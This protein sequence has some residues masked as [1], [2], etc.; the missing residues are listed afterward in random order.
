V[1]TNFP[2][3]PPFLFFSFFLF[4]PLSSLSLFFYP[5][6]FLQKASNGGFVLPLKKPF[7]PPCGSGPPASAG[8]PAPFSGHELWT[9]P[10]SKPPLCFPKQWV[11]PPLC[12]PVFWGESGLFRTLPCP[13][14]NP[15]VT[16][17]NPTWVGTPFDVGGELGC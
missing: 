4:P 11:T 17:I 5:A 15:G 9:Q 14:P 13:P 3:P 16:P 12:W 2:I 8:F 6:P 7:D 10:E 1:R